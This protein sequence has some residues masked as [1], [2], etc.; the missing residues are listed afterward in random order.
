LLE[1]DIIE[2]QRID[3]RSLNNLGTSYFNSSQLYYGYG[4]NANNAGTK[5][6]APN[7]YYYNTG[8]SEF[9]INSNGNLTFS[10]QTCRS[11]S[12]SNGCFRYSYGADYDSNGNVYGVDRNYMRLQKFNSNLSYQRKTEAIIVE[13]AHFIIHGVYMWIEIIK[14]MSQIITITR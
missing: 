8:L 14:Y 5:L 11:Y 9:N 2:F 1:I 10:R 4:L 12:T 13:V 6:I 7:A 3:R